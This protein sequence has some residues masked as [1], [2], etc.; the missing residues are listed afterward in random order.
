MLYSPD[1]YRDELRGHAFDWAAKITEKSVGAKS[2]TYLHERQR[3][4]LQA[5]AIESFLSL[6]LSLLSILF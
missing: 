3:D 6:A 2:V 1:N 4:F 5:E